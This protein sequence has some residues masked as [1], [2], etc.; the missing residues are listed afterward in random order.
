MNSNKYSV[1]TMFYRN[2][3]PDRNQ[4][5]ANMRCIVEQMITYYRLNSTVLKD[6]KNRSNQMCPKIHAEN[7]KQTFIRRG[8]KLVELKK[9]PTPKKY[10]SNRMM[11]AYYGTPDEYIDVIDVI[12]NQLYGNRKITIPKSLQFN[13]IFG[14]PVEGMEKILKM[15][16]NGQIIILNEWR[17]EDFVLDNIIF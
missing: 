16:I 4:D 6:R 1:G 2:K 3:S 15:R 9:Q 12:V 5:I 10:I 14:D 11:Y 17:D 7:H 8:R 13:D